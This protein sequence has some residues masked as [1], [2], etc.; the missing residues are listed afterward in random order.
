M[1]FSSLIKL[2]RDPLLKAAISS[3][4]SEWLNLDS[5][6]ENDLM[7]TGLANVSVVIDKVNRELLASSPFAL[8]KFSLGK[9]RVSVNSDNG[10]LDVFVK[11]ADIKIFLKEDLVDYQTEVKEKNQPSAGTSAQSS[12]SS[13]LKKLTQLSLNIEIDGATV[14]IRPSRRLVN[15]GFLRAKV[16]KISF[17]KKANQ[18][19]EKLHASLKLF[20]IS[21]AHVAASKTEETS[22][23]ALDE[24]INVD[25]EL[26][27]TSKMFKVVVKATVQSVGVLLTPSTSS[28][29]MLFA[30]KIA[31]FT[32]A[33]EFAK[34]GLIRKNDTSAPQG[35]QGQGALSGPEPSP[36]SLAVPP[37]A[38][39][40]NFEPRE[41]ELSGG[42]IDIS[43][44]L[45]AAVFAFAGDG[46][47]E[48]RIQLQK[49]THSDGEPASIRFGVF[50]SLQLLIENLVLKVSDK[51][52]V[53][54]I[55]SVMLRE[56][57]VDTTA[58]LNGGVSTQNPQNNSTFNSSLFF[59]SAMD[60]NE[61]GIRA[62]TIFKIS[63]F[64]DPQDSSCFK[65]KLNDS[66]FTISLGEVNLNAEMA[67]KALASVSDR[68]TRACVASLAAGARGSGENADFL[69]V[70]RI[71]FKRFFELF[72]QGSGKEI[73]PRLLAMIEEAGKNRQIQIKKELPAL[74]LGVKRIVISLMEAT[75][76]FFEAKTLKIQTRPAMP[77]SAVLSLEYLS[78]FEV[79]T[80]KNISL[81]MM[82]P[83]PEDQTAFKPSLRHLFL[84]IPS[85]RI[86]S[87]RISNFIFD[88]AST[89]SRL[90][91]SAS[92]CS[93]VVKGMGEE[94]STM[95]LAFEVFPERIEFLQA[96]RSV[97]TQEAE[98]NELQISLSAE[99]V[100]IS[101][102]L[103][104]KSPGVIFLINNALSERAKR[105]ESLCVHIVD[106]SSAIIP[107]EAPQVFEL[108]SGKVKGIKASIVQNIFEGL[109]FDCLNLNM[110]RNPLVSGIEYCIELD[111]KDFSLKSS[112]IRCSS[113]ATLVNSNEKILEILT[114]Y[115]VDLDKSLAPRLIPFFNF[116]LLKG[117]EKP[118]MESCSDIFISACSSLKL[119]RPTLQL[120]NFELI[121]NDFFVKAKVSAQKMWSNSVD[122]SVDFFKLSKLTQSNFETPLVIVSKLHAF[123][124]Q[125]DIEST[126]FLLAETYIK[127]LVD[128]SASIQKIGKEIYTKLKES[129]VFQKLYDQFNESKDPKPVETPPVKSRKS[130]FGFN[131]VS[132]MSETYKSFDTCLKMDSFSSPSLLFF[133]TALN[134][135]SKSAP[136]WGFGA[137]QM[138]I[139]VKNISALFK[140]PD[141][142][143][144][145]GVELGAFF[146]GMDKGKIGLVVEKLNL[147]E[148]KMSGNLNIVSNLRKDFFIKLYMSKGNKT[149]F[150]LKFDHLSLLLNGNVWNYLDLRLEKLISNYVWSESS[151]GN[152]N[153]FDQNELEN[154]KNLVDHAVISEIVIHS[155]LNEKLNPLLIINEISNYNTDKPVVEFNDIVNAF[156]TQ[157]ASSLKDFCKNLGVAGSM[158]AVF[159]V[160]WR[161]VYFLFLRR[162][163]RNVNY[164]IYKA[165]KEQIFGP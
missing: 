156:S 106:D 116:S 142:E 39:S 47:Y 129:T 151:S 66:I 99:V 84:T 113:L 69:E 112:L 157:I 61:S 101:V 153:N 5:L 15:C 134:E 31:E 53:W 9:L 138:K 96:A 143:T 13:L 91:D 3:I 137:S 41:D 43:F 103:G 121:L 164:T 165:V 115:L 55:S 58:S 133:E 16:G 89:A 8:D 111:L 78:L 97:Q 145:F 11:D 32:S 107:S 74:L 63:S 87:N 131:I 14:E 67:L 37:G 7:G 81:R 77:Q 10:N 60:A 135:F 79:V 159:F 110:I 29:L 28:T 95:G 150:F 76:P 148:K 98:G 40:S 42:D 130:S 80:I 52:V 34:S 54:A 122:H 141:C 23:V 17:L 62:S 49:P 94:F 71:Y 90:A 86:E 136:E 6:R 1:Y 70:E 140:D 72:G 50:E 114:D 36:R 105:L 56:F 126:E 163:F 2:V 57:Q 22:F 18:A 160:V 155:M 45:G 4:F 128:F 51:C 92:L 109:T 68:V 25:I 65:G 102:E 147:Y 73:G 139:F 149:N 64:F 118:V 27:P 24:K 19:G 26:V 33:N 127:S 119:P 30:A 83:K 82:E 44:E 146:V 75:T 158:R 124:N 20:D 35:L 152:S 154:T 120:D 12:E 100:E 161:I 123:E 93:S 104:D 38:T 21:L 162:N 108:L 59:Q 88:F 48:E 46:D 117:E 132:P 125:I 85:V 144:E